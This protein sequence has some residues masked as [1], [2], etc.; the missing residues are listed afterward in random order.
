MTMLF[1]CSMVSLNASAC[2]CA[3]Y[4]DERP[5]PSWVYAQ[6][7]NAHAIHASGASMCTG[8]KHID[9][10]RADTDGR[11]ALSKILGT[12]VQTT[13]TTKLTVRNQTS[14]SS[15]QS[16]S[17]L[18]SKQLLK[19]ATVFDRWVDAENCI[20]YSAM[21]VS[22]TDI[23]AAKA[24]EESE[25]QG[26][27]LAKNACVLAKGSNA[28]LSSKSLTAL[29]TQ[30]GFIINSAKK[31]QIQYRITTDIVD[32][33]NDFVK[34]QTQVVVGHGSD[35]LW[36]KTYPGKSLSFNRTS[37]SE[38]VKAAL[39]DSLDQFQSDLAELKNIK[40]DD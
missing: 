27:L 19:N 25:K 32:T 3:S 28:N 8:M 13:E 31:C 34:S 5:A 37:R 20:V 24:A 38:L 30:Q 16:L 23:E 29:L 18:Q 21:K 9:E 4:Y 26:K 10:R 12:Q 15:F 7:A 1:L 2:S 40:V 33:G 11:G 39:W 6:A 36:Q 22:F 17:L 35:L 14:L